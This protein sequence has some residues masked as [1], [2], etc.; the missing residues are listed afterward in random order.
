MIQY[1]LFKQSLWNRYHLVIGSGAKIPFGT[2]SLTNS[3]GLPFNA[4]MQPGTGAFDGIFLSRAGFSLLPLAKMDLSIITSYR[5]TGKNSRFNENDEY[6]FG[7]EFISTFRVSGSITSRLSYSGGLLYRSTSSD[8]LNEIN[9]PNTGGK[10]LN[11]NPELL[12]SL[13]DR[14]YLKAG[15]QIPIWQHL[16]GTQPTTTYTLSTSLYININPPKNNFTHGNK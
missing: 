7:N 5:L 6:E 16:N 11:L 12:Y 15:G 4:D 9:L 8:R 2:T 13:S 3:N 1:S 14:F 10:W